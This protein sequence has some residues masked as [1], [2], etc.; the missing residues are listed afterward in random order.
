MTI[1]NRISLGD[2]R[3]MPIGDIACLPAE[4][5]ML[6]QDEADETLRA[7]K[8]IRDWLEGAIALKYADRAHAI[9]QEAG[10]DTGTVRL[11]DGAVTVIA[12]LPKKVEWDQ[13]DLA[14]LVEHIKA[15]GDD[16]TDYVDVSFKV[17]ERKYGAWPKNIRIA[18]EAAR[19]LRVGKASYKLVTNLGESE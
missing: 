15:S 6:L 3:H 8:A 13:H 5:L 14:R 18:F 12:D 17:S 2:L 7:A 9:R 19:K 1:S 16:P 4:Q 11:S 10:K